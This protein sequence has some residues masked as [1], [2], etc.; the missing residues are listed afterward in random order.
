MELFMVIAHKEL[1]TI[2][3][4]LERYKYCMDRSLEMITLSYSGCSK[5]RTWKI[6]QLDDRSNYKSIVSLLDTRNEELIVTQ[7]FPCFVKDVLW[8]CLKALPEN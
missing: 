3:K 1:L 8:M 4:T 7:I 6:R 5:L 2:I